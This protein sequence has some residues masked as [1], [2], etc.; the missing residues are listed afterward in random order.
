ML[1]RSYLTKWIAKF[2]VNGQISTSFSVSKVIPQ[3]SV[4]GPLLFNCYVGSLNRKFESTQIF[5]YVDDIN[6][7]LPM[8]NKDGIATLQKLL[9]YKIGVVKIGSPLTLRYQELYS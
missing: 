2:K 4:L 6:L 9:T 5:K 1:G 3:G 8:K 7:V